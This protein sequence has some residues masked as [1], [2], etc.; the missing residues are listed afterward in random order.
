MT[1]RSI[2]IKRFIRTDIDSL[3]KLTQDPAQHERWDARFG[4][5][6]YEPTEEDGK[7]R[8]RYSVTVFPGVTIAGTGECTALRT[9]GRGVSVSGIRFA[10][11]SKLS[12]LKSGSGYWRYEPVAGGVEF[13]TQYDYQVRWGRVG[14]WVDLLWRPLMARMTAWSFDRLRLWA[15]R[16]VRPELS[17]LLTLVPLSIVVTATLFVAV[18]AGQPGWLPVAAAGGLVAQW[19]LSQRFLPKAG[20]CQWSVGPTPD[21]A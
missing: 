20:R 14:R 10:S 6:S 21:R 7:Q 11:E 8:L 19:F 2:T 1:G 17:L 13:S 5:I 18:G 15:E 4:H 12:L 3:W 9:S 16:G